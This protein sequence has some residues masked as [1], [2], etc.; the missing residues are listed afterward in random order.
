MGGSPTDIL[1]NRSVLQCIDERT[2]GL[3]TKR[4]RGINAS[5]TDAEKQKLLLLTPVFFSLS[6][7]GPA[8]AMLKA[9]TRLRWWGLK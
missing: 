5:A 1:S 8:I 4:L 7:D 2:L 3:Q 6:D 9:N